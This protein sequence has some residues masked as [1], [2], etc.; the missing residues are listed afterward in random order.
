MTSCPRNRLCRAAFA[1]AL[2]LTVPSGG[3]FAVHAGALPDLPLL[4]LEHIQYEGAFRLP[5][6]TFGESSLDYSEGPLEYNAANNSIFIVGHNHQQA[7]AEFAVPDI[8]NSDALGDLNMADAPVQDFSTILG[9]PSGGN[10]QEINTIGGME[11]VTGAG[12]AQLLVNAYEYYDAPG[13]NTHSTLVIRDAGDLAGSQ[14]DGYFQFEGGAGHTSGW[15]SPIPSEWQSI[16]GGT[17]ITGQSS[18]IPIISR[19][20][21]GPSAFAFAP[22][23]IVG[24]GSVPVPVPTVKL[25]DFSL[26]H[27]LHTDLSNDSGGNDLWTHLSR[28]TYGLVVPGTR[29]YATFGYSGGHES[30]VCYKCTQNNGN[31]CGGYCAPDAG[32]YYQYYWLWDV[33]DLVSVKNGEMNSY[34]VRPYGCGE[35]ATPFETSEHQIGGGTF[36]PASGLLYLTVQRADRDQG[37]YANPPV[38][39]V[40][41]FDLTIPVRRLPDAQSAAQGLD[42]RAI[43]AANGGGV[44]LAL[45]ASRT[46]HVIVAVYNVCGRRV[47]VLHD[48][49]I[50]AGSSHCVNLQKSLLGDG[51]Y[52]VRA[53][54]EDA[55]AGLRVAVVE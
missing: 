6:G 48:G 26:D 10:T 27:P 46:Q 36:D 9:R 16:L 20:T 23:D 15:I 11:L 1:A 4:S 39:I 14:V 13:D 42:L 34:D 33:Y 50:G 51:S 3:R 2:I 19:T 18:G 38:V 5:T 40:Y 29:T 7:I 37:T 8:V 21:V 32:D 35:F 52:V 41:S 44:T 55:S 12:G 22:R 45:R 47:A 25:L 24:T 31:L 49:M 30:G 28:A 43:R 53:T 17:H 54:G